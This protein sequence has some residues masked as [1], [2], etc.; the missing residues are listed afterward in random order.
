MKQFRTSTLTAPIV[1]M[2]K[3]A[4][5]IMKEVDS[6]P[7]GEANVGILA[8]V[9]LGFVFVLWPLIWII[10]M[11]NYEEAGTPEDAQRFPLFS[12][13]IWFLFC[14]FAAYWYSLTCD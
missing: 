11:V 3:M 4:N 14:N 2:W 1:L 5:V 7:S 6:D 10:L 13:L 8:A 12:W 9:F